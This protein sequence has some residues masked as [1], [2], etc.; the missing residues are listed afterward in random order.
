MKSLPVHQNNAVIG[1]PADS[2]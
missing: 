1:G 2:Q